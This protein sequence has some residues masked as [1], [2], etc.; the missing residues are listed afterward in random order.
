M[1][2]AILKGPT[3]SIAQK[4][5]LEA[6]PFAD[7]LE[8]RL[9]CFF[10]FSLSELDAFAKSLPLPKIF[11]LRKKSQGGECALEGQKRIFLIWKLIEL[12]PDYFDIEADEGE[13]LFCELKRAFPRVELIASHHVETQTALD[14]FSL[15]SSMPKKGVDH[16]KIVTQVTSS[17][18]AL[19]LLKFLKETKGKIT[20]LA[21][22]KTGEFARI[23]SPI[24][25]S[26]FL[27]GHALCEG[28]LGQI[29]LKDL[30]EIYHVRQMNKNTS[31]Y[32]LL[33]GDVERSLSPLFHNEVFHSHH[34][35]AV[36][37]KI[38]LKPEE[39]EPFLGEAKE[40]GFQGMS[41]TMPYKE[42]ILPLVDERT[43][44][45]KKIGAVNTLCRKDGG[46][47]GDNVDGKGVLDA[48]EEKRA[49]KRKH[50]VVL[51]SGGFARAIVFEAVQRKALVKVFARR[52]EKRREFASSFH[53]P[54]YD[55]ERLD[56]FLQ[57]EGYD[58]LI[59]ATC[60]GM[61]PEI[62][63]LL[64]HTFFA[65]SLIVEGVNSR[66][67][68]LLQRAKEEGIEVIEGQALF[69]KQAL[70]QQKRWP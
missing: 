17:L 8:I 18:E 61:N 32:A 60:N 20:A 65:G 24:F 67:T 14:L 38:S 64:V 37:V 31:I 2:V 59:N 7:L 11:T 57:K 40:L 63:K 13:E 15:Y 45:A 36:Y 51:G 30:M 49:V 43:S 9:D 25:G 47:V 66:E 27:Y 1:L 34:K 29:S 48:I 3:F 46:W 42:T 23:L 21:T 26:E 12:G 53:I 69:R 44:E 68:K 58:I 19:R 10:P 16:Y 33:G 52:E 35:N 39:L 50:L 5:A 4:Q 28:D 62:E 55:L 22:L 54:A 56:E 6:L 41:V 70:L